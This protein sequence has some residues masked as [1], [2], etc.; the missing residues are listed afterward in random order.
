MKV[1]YDNLYE[2]WLD[3]SQKSVIGKALGILTLYGTRG[4][5]HNKLN[6]TIIP[7]VSNISQ[8]V[9]YFNFDSMIT[10]KCL[11]SEEATLRV[12]IKAGG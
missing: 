9:L 12:A 8:H 10:F 5:R 2:S 1:I 3:K 4:K 11:G 6:E 7:E